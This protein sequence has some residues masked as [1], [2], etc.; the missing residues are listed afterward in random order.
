MLLATH[1]GILTSARSTSPHGLASQL[2]ERSPTEAGTLGNRTQKAGAKLNL[3]S[4]TV[5]SP[6]FRPPVASVPGL[7]PVILSAQNHLTSEL[8]R[9]L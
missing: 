4:W 1:T 6:S 5:M 7:S 8:L 9:T 3:S 2:A